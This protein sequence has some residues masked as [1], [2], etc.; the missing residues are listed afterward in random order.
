MSMVFHSKDLL[1]VNI[2]RFDL[3]VNAFIYKQRKEPWNLV[4]FL[5]M[6]ISYIFMTCMLI[7]VLWWWFWWW[8]SKNAQ[9]V[10]V[11]Q[12]SDSTENAVKHNQKFTKCMDYCNEY[13]PKIWG[14][15]D[16]Q[17]VR[18]CAASAPTIRGRWKFNEVWPNLNQIWGSP[19][20]NSNKFVQNAWKVYGKSKAR[21]GWKF[22]EVW[23]KVNQVCGTPNEYFHQVCPEMH[24]KSWFIRGHE[25][26]EIQRSVTK[27]PWGLWTPLISI[28]IEF[29][30]NPI[31]SMSSNVQ[32]RNA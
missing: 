17:F 10:L 23:P 3:L 13:F 1:Y 29:E 27:I 25:M 7:T 31:I 21:I 30:V 20:D 9:K 15:S 12:R 16:E 18:K 32:K 5:H 26:T 4:D 28:S 2:C 24:K 8:L 6:Q 22:K 11:N 14:Q 19:N